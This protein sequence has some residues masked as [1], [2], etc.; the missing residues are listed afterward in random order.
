MRLILN[1]FALN[2]I[3]KSKSLYRTFALQRLYKVILY[4]RYNASVVFKELIQSK[5]AT[6]VNQTFVEFKCN[7]Y[8]PFIKKCSLLSFY[9]CH[10]YIVYFD[11]DLKNRQNIDENCVLS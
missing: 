9:I 1:V 4:T 5:I 11:G 10:F 8:I 7:R 2:I 6:V 3:P